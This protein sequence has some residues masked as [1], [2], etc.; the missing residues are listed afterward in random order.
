MV[1]W[2]RFNAVGIGG[3][4]LQVAL[5]WALEF[6]GVH[7]LLATAIAVEAALLHNFWWHVRWTWSDR[8]PSLLRFH[9]A[10]GLVSMVSN[11]VWMRVFTGV[12]EMP[13]A[14]ANVLAIGIS[15]LL[16]FALSDRWVFAAAD[17]AS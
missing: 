8:R 7:Y 13:V 5:L 10:N 14:G 4:V 11:L 15:S 2:L 1:T 9:V 6:S 17:D 12:L 3:A 16:N